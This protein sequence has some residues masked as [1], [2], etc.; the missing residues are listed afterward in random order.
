LA[1]PWTTLA[2]VTLAASSSALAWSYRWA[3]ARACAVDLDAV[4]P[5][6]R[7]LSGEQRAEQL[8]RLAPSDSWEHELSSELLR[9]EGDG[10]RLVAI[11]DTLNSVDHRM[12]ARDRWPWA[13]AWIT[14]SGSLLIAVAGVL[15]GVGVELLWGLAAGAVG[16]VACLRARS[17]GRR[18]AARRRAA[19]DALVELLAGELY[20]RE[21]EL[22]RRRRPRFRRA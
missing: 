4:L 1:D 3:V 22:P 15:S 20:H 16:V 9:A 18:L 17:S 8:E 10:A 13:A 21:V 5:Q 6:L 19:V 14:G 11:N 12:L 2:S 7:A